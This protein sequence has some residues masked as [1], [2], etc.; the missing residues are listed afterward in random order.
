M[1]EV[2]MAPVVCLPFFLSFSLSKEKGREGSGRAT[3]STHGRNKASL[4]P[5]P[6]H[7]S[8]SAYGRTIKVLLQFVS[9][10][11]V[12]KLLPQ[13]FYSIIDHN[14]QFSLYCKAT[15]DICI[16]T[17]TCS[18]DMKKQILNHIHHKFKS[19]IANVNNISADF[20]PKKCKKCIQITF[21]KTPL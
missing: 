5:Q 11:H 18:V 3:L 7:Y 16:N 17:L 15:L 4:Q 19:Q 21:S 14:I 1:K 10:K 13:H 8:F 9:G 20:K 2:C 12:L 6:K